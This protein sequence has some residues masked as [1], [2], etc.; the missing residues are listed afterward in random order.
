MKRL[1]KRLQHRVWLW[2][3][4]LVDM[5]HPGYLRA[6]VTVGRVQRFYE[7][8]HETRY[9]GLAETQHQVATQ[10]PQGPVDSSQTAQAILE[11]QEQKVESKARELRLAF[12]QENRLSE[13]TETVIDLRPW[14]NADKVP[15]HVLTRAL[16]VFIL[17]YTRHMKA[18]VGTKSSTES[19]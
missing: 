7:L 11:Q 17:A 19:Q 3:A 13:L 10:K 6:E 12:M 14:E 1:L 16:A 8:L 9:N 5:L 15:A 2:L 4:G 18:L